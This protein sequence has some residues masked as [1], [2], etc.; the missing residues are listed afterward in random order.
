MTRILFY[1]I[2]GLLISCTPRNK[3]TEPVDTLKAITKSQNND[4]TAKSYSVE[5]CV[6]NNDYKELTIEWLNE[7]KIKDYIWRD[8]LKQALVPKG[9]D[10]VFVSKGGCNH[11]GLLVELKLTNDNHTLTDSTYWIEKSLNI[12]IEYQMDHYEQ[13]I[14]ERRLKKAESGQKKIWYEI[15]DTD[16]KDNLIFNGIEISADGPIK[17]VSISQYFN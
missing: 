4:S 13:M 17:K 3:E 9:Q 14:K 8:D 6:F 7:L 12:S 5:D 16:P 11:L 15:D 10:T 1:T 2:I